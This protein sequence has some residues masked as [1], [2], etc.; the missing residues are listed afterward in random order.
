[1][2]WRLAAVPVPP[3]HLSF[4]FGRSPAL[5]SLLML[6]GGRFSILSRGP[7]SRVVRTRQVQVHVFVLADLLTLEQEHAF[8]GR[9]S[10]D[11]IFRLFGLRL[12]PVSPHAESNPIPLQAP[13]ESCPPSLLCLL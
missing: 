5:S 6:A 2:G 9:L 7:C 11:L 4:T 1:M 3:L 12:P 8:D 13:R 10:D